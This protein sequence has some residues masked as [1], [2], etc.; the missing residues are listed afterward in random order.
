ML[1]TAPSLVDL[2]R[3]PARVVDV[4]LSAVQSL[5]TQAPALQVALAARLAGTSREWDH[6]WE[7]RH[8]RGAGQRTTESH[9]RPHPLREPTPGNRCEKVRIG[10]S[11][12]EY[13]SARATP[14]DR[15]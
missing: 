1:V 10:G 14:E 7:A 5:M 13:T 9:Q 15:G 2:A 3:D 11:R 4:S 8:F 6:T 12:G